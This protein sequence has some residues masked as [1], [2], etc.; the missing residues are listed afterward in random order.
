[1]VRFTKM[2]GLGNDFVVFD[3]VTQAVSLTPERVR[4]L[5]DRR[6]GI[7]C[8]QVLLVERP[9]RPGVDFRYRIFNSDGGE[10]EQ[11]GN[12]ARCFVRF[13]RDKQL[14]RQDEI[15]VLARAFDRMA[16][17]L[18]VLY[19]D[20]PCAN[21]ITFHQGRLF[22]GECRPDGRIVELDLNGGAARTVLA[23]V[24]MPNAMEVGP[25]GMLYFPVMGANEIWRIDPAGGA[26]EKVAGDL[27]VPDAVKFDAQGKPLGQFGTPGY[28]EGQLDEPVGL[29]VDRQGRVVHRLH[30]AVSPQTSW[31][32]GP[33]GHCTQPGS[34]FIPRPAPRAGRSDAFDD[35]D[36]RPYRT[37]HGVR[38]GQ[39]ARRR[40]GRGCGMIPPAAVGATPAVSVEDA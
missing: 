16:E 29:A 19:G 12:G 20:L 39:S 24:P 33:A 31:R 27:G 35:S 14:T 6:R 3:A 37:R 34:T 32:A 26:P 15:G 22:A 21:P 18:R 28:L 2:H 4:R 5:A 10:V 7:G 30:V 11:C 9:T 25:D 36:R 38:L 1:M 17:E 13:V 23:N 40:G 8:D